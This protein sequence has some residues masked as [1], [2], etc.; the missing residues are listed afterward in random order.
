MTGKRWSELS[1]PQ[2]RLVLVLA[3]AQVTL[4]GIAWLDLGFRPAE[5][6]NGRKSWW[7]AVIAVNVVGP[8]SYLR[9][10]RKTEVTSSGGKR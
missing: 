1:L 3:A 8:L 2:R 9:W 6:V 7:A 10:G 5:A 4:A